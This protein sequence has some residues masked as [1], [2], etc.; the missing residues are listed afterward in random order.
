MHQIVLK[1]NLVQTP[2]ILAFL[3]ILE[4]REI[5]IATCLF[6]PLVTKSALKHYLNVNALEPVVWR[7]C[8][9]TCQVIMQRLP[10]GICKNIGFAKI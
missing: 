6:L 7:D 10:H 4:C 5:S 9:I 1:S 8:Q 2:K 3:S